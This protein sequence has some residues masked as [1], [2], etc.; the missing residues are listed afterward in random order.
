MSTSLRT[1]GLV[2]VTVAFVGGAGIAIAQEP[3]PASPEADAATM[4]HDGQMPEVDGMMPM[5]RMME[6]MS[7][8]MDLCEEMMGKSPAGDGKTS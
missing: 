3:A 7:A 6:R 4:S 8:M 1:F 5:M 2:A